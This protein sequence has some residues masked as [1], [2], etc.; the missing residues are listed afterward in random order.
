MPSRAYLVPESMAEIYDSKEAF[1]HRL[2]LEIREKGQTSG[3][4]KAS[5]RA[6]TWLVEVWTRTNLFLA[7]RRG[8]LDDLT[9]SAKM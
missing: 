3:P 6:W 4:R 1:S 7:W 9:A 8:L 5:V 2:S